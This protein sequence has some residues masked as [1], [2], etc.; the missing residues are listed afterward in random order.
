MRLIIRSDFPAASLKRP[1]GL[2]PAGARQRQVGRALI[3]GTDAIVTQLRTQSDGTIYRVNQKRSSPP[4]IVVRTASLGMAARAVED[5]LR[6]VDPR[7]RP[8]TTIVRKRARCVTRPK[9]MLAL[10]SGPAAVLAL[11]LA[12]L[13]VYIV[14][15]FVSASARTE[16][17]RTGG[18]SGRQPYIRLPACGDKSARSARDNEVC[19]SGVE[20]NRATVSG[21]AAQMYGA[22]PMPPRPGSQH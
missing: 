19:A 10:P 5:V 15:A 3:G 9:R 20:C 7:I 13:G 4:I 14:T 12:G 17:R 21:A 16:S 18:G 1:Y 22:A 6:R 2:Q 8:T 11:V